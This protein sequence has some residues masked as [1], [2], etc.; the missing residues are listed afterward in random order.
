MRLHGGAVSVLSLTCVAFTSN[1]EALVVSALYAGSYDNYGLHTG[2]QV[3]IAGHDGNPGVD[4]RNFLV[5]DLGGLGGQVT[6]AT[7]RLF[8][9]A[10][11]FA[12]GYR[13]PDPQETYTLFDVSTPHDELMTFSGLYSAAGLQRFADLGSGTELGSVVVSPAD[14]GRMV[15]ILFN[16]S[17]LA[18][19]NG[20]LGGTFAV[21]GALTTLGPVR[22]GEYVFGFTYIG[23]PTKELDLELASVPEPGTMLLVGSGLLALGL[24]RRRA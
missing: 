24:R 2:N 15:E 7:L 21:G 23:S 12:N 3:Y 18:A 11:G 8:N 14:N 17:G 16:A 9:P 5:F 10:L 20:A 1:A 13:S 6:G 4:Y 22:G 19:I